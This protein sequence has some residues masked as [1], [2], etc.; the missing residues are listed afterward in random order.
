MGN[1]KGLTL[2][3]VVIAL[4]LFAIAVVMAYPI[5][6]LAGKSNLQSKEKLVLQETGTFVAENIRYI[7]LNNASSKE[8][9]LNSG[10]LE[11]YG[12]C[13]EKVNPCSNEGDIIVG[14]FSRV[15]NVYT[16]DYGQQVITLEFE[17]GSNIVRI[18]IQGQNSKYETLEYLR[19]EG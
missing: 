4:A 5:I 13:T 3:E 7:T 9:F 11:S 15:E 17:E 6:T 16:L 2:V 1:K 19:Y 12:L 10:W 8:E 14:S 18:K